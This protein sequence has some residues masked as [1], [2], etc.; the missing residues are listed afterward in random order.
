MLP[1]SMYTQYTMM[2]VFSCFSF[3][4]SATG[5]SS[6]GVIITQSGSAATALP[7]H[8]AQHQHAERVSSFKERVPPISMLLSKDLCME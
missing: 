4:R 8:V 7:E 1:S 6:V 5:L 3:V 2:R